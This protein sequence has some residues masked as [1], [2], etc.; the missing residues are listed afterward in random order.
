MIGGRALLSL[1]AL[2]LLAPAARA[3]SPGE[4]FLSID[5]GRW[6]I[7]LR[8]L[9]DGLELD[10]DGDGQLT[11]EEIRARQADIAAFAL[12]GLE[13]Q[14]PAGGCGLSAGALGLTRHDGAAF[15]ALPL[16]LDCPPGAA[17][18]TLRYR[19]FLERDRLHQAL[20]SAGGQTRVLRPGADTWTFPLQAP[21]AGGWRAFAHL[22]GE[23]MWHIWQGLDHV[24]FLIALLLP[25]VVSGGS[26]QPWSEAT[27]LR[28]TLGEVARIVTAFTAAHSLTLSLA[29]LGLLQVSARIIE[30]AIAASVVL[31][32]ANNLRP[33]FG[34]ERWAVAFA[35]GLLHGFGFAGALADLGLDRGR[36]LPALLGFNL[37]VEVGQ[38]ALVALFVPLAFLL[39]RTAGYRRL[40]LQGGSLAIASLALV[41]LVERAFEISLPSLLP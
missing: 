38:L 24:L 16:V 10:A 1:L 12:A 15:A 29:A 30:P 13:V 5:E 37:G 20:V 17:A 40:G 36:L 33:I 34:R 41:W 6:E 8:D 4:S 35:L 23:G 25:S 19:L 9:D 3:H 32:A 11:G 27:S 26:R 21:G 31:A 28:A 7:A 39:R 18:A 2:V 14:T 22:V